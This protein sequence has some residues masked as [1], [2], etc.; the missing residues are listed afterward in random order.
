MAIRVQK[1]FTRDST[2][3]AIYYNYDDDE[4]LADATSVSISIKDPDGTMVA[5]D[6]AMS[7]TAT[8]VYEY[9]YTTTTSVVV[10]KYQVE[11]VALDGS[12]KTMESSSFEM[13]AGI[14]E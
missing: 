6:Q 7:K 5:D 13:I 8:G 10:G 12:Y 11:V 14:N 4:V 9:F 2:V 1:K 3:R